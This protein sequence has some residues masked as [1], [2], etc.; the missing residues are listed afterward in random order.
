MTEELDLL[1]ELRRQKGEPPHP[2]MAVE[3]V[4]YA[5]AVGV[6]ARV[7]SLDAPDFRIISEY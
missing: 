1:G 7:G 4:L 6:Y 2:V 3:L 5:Y